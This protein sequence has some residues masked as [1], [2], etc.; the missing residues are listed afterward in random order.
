MLIILKI[1]RW[2]LSV[3]VIVFGAVMV[4]LAAANDYLSPEV[5]V[6]TSDGSTIYVAEA[7][8]NQIA[9]FDVTTNT[10]TQVISLPEPNFPRGLALSPDGSKLYV[11]KALPEGEVQ[12]ISTSTHTVVDTIPA[13]HTPM[14]PVVSPD[15]SKLYVSNRF[16]NTVSAI[17]IATKQEVVIPVTREP[18]AAD[19]TQDGNF[20]L[21]TNY[22]PAGAATGTMGGV[23]SVINTASNSVVATIQLPNGCTSL[24]GIC[25]SPDGQYAYVTHLLGRNYIPTNQI[26]RGWIWTNALSIIDVAS[27]SLTATV[28]LDDVDMGAANPWDVTCTADGNYLCVSH[29]GTHELSV[30]DRNALH[31][32]LVTTTRPSSDLGFMAGIRRRLPLQGNGPR[33]LALIGTKAY[34]AEYFTGSLGVV[35]IDPNNAWPKAA[36]ISLGTEPTLTDV[37]KGERLYY[38]AQYC[39]QKWLSCS[40]CHPDARTDTLNW[41]ILNDGF[42]NTKQTKSHLLSHQTPPTTITGCRPDAETSVRAGLLY[43]EFTIRPESEA[44]EIDEYLKSLRAVPSPYLVNG[45]PSAAAQNGKLLFEG[46][47]GCATCHSTPFITDLNPYDV[48]TGTGIEAGTAFDTPTLVEVWRTAPYLY[49]GQAATMEEVLTT[50]NPG[51]Q[52]GTTSGLTPQEIADLA[53]YVLSIGTE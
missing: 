4:N 49:Q 47:A 14:A 51:D 16:D 28:L 44:V 12:V 35:D 23:V 43:I 20:L 36:S 30:I 40:S 33:G 19:I 1:R 34:T 26:E 18:M 46:S 17:T 38:D 31:T 13:G 37:R 21:V 27:K 29:A 5:V 15:G 25:I 42:G 10:V 41:D 8:A 3:G 22:L 48:G 39:F 9:V 11:T 24:Q 6:A 52:H 53:E 32:K 45:Q 7:T 2:I 50:F